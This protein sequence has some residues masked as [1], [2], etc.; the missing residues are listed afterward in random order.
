MFMFHVKNHFALPNW[1]LHKSQTLVYILKAKG[2]ATL[3]V[4]GDHCTGNKE[5]LFL[6][7]TKILQQGFTH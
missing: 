5:K 3:S 2:D 6:I 1:I 4:G 7:L